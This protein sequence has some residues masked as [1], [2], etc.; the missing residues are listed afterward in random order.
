MLMIFVFKCMA[1]FNDAILKQARIHKFIKEGMGV[2]ET[3][4]GVEM[5]FFIT[6]QVI[7]LYKYKNQ[8]DN[9]LL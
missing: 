7:K 2:D 4:R 6:I 5:K 3:K 1:C 8:M 9:V